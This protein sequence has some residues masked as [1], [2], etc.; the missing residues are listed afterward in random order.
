M[1]PLASKIRPVSLD[2]FV[3]QQHLVGPGK[4]VRLAIEQGHVFSFVLWGTPGTGKTTLAR[5]YANAINAHFYELSA[6]SAGKDDIRK[7]VTTV[8][9]FSS[10]TRFI[11]SIRPNR[12][13]CCHSSRAANSS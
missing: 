12:I 6:V 8:Q 11:D 2:E 13:F 3:G 4:P 10:S 9:K 5:I 1:E 7:I